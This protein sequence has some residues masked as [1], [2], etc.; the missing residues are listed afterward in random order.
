MYI[1]DKLRELLISPTLNGELSIP[2][3]EFFLET[4]NGP[5]P[6]AATLQISTDGDEFLLDVRDREGRNLR[7]FF[8]AKKKVSSEDV[9]KASGVIGCKLRVEFRKIWPPCSSTT[10]PIG[11]I[12]SS[13]A[14]FE[15]EEIWI[16][17]Q[18]DDAWT[19]DEIK[20]H[21]GK[22]NPHKAPIETEKEKSA[23]EPR[24]EH[25][26]IFANTKIQF[27]NGGVKWEQ[28]HP[29]WGKIG[30][31][32]DATWDGVALGG[33]FS[34]KQAGNHLEVGFRHDGDDD[35]EARLK[36]DA[37]IQAVAYTHAIFPWPTFIQRRRDWKV[38]EQT[39]K[40]VR[41]E[42]GKM[43]PL[44]DRDGFESANSPTDLIA[45]VAN[46]FEE[47]SESKRD[48]LK[49]IM[50]VFRGADSRSAPSPLQMA[51]VCS[52]IEGLRTE[53]FKKIKP[54]AVFKEVR[55]E[56]LEWIKSL[57]TSATSPE[58]VAMAKRLYGWVDGW[59]PNDRRVEWNEV[60]LN[61]FPGREKWVVDLFKLFQNHRHGPA[62]GDY[63]SPTKGD[64]HSTIEALGRLAGFV[65]LIVAAKAGYKG[66]IL[67]S[68]FS[69]RR[70]DL[71][72]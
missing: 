54:P 24:F 21:L 70:M 64:P 35:D 37:L 50:W 57:E 30:G 13:S 42:Q 27:F 56:A 58:K 32:K 18:T 65:N 63:G 60:F 33:T 3:D 41:Q 51:M 49:Q 39:L 6:L 12:Q 29:F 28:N 5:V 1:D 53:L 38:M 16:I 43:V 61:L 17:P 4:A 72:N 11:D 20:D 40:V 52:V 67:E 10:R 55:Q 45:S 48:E 71:G 9:L 14:K 31:S 7:G 19:Y 22:L 8:T 15:P 47:L 68:P 62:H 25:I 44:R 26:A 34:L 69:D 46:F 36:F 2:V 59:P 23:K 66:R